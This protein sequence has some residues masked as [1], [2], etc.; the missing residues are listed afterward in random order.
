[1]Q[2][3]SPQ[4]QAWLTHS[5]QSNGCSQSSSEI[6]LTTESGTRSCLA[7]NTHE[8]EWGAWLECLSCDNEK[9]TAVCFP[10]AKFRVSYILWEVIGVLADVSVYRRAAKV[11]RRDVRDRR[12]VTR[13]RCRVTRSQSIFARQDHQHAHHHRTLRTLRINAASRFL[14]SSG[15]WLPHLSSL[16]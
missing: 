5:A 8:H 11:I 9:L 1:M 2:W 13:C 4:K 12:V 6:V 15:I 3:R 10:F 7:R 14:V 16:N